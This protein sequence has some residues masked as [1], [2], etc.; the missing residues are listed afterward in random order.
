[1]ATNILANLQVEINNIHI[2]FE[3]GKAPVR[4]LWYYIIL[5]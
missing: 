5:Y 2:R 1:M 3:D 4:L